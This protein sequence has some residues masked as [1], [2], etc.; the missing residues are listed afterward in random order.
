MVL[1]EYRTCITF[2]KFAMVVGSDCSWMH[3]QLHEDKALKWSASVLCRKP[4]VELFSSHLSVVWQT[5]QDFYTWLNVKVC[6]VL[7]VNDELAVRKTE[8]SD[9]IWVYAKKPES[10]LFCG[11]LRAIKIQAEY[12]ILGSHCWA[13]FCPLEPSSCPMYIYTY[14]I[15]TLS[16]STEN[17]YQM[18]GPWQLCISLSR[19]LLSRYLKPNFFIVFFCSIFFWHTQL[20]KRPFSYPSA[21]NSASVQ[22]ISLT[23]STILPF[24]FRPRPSLFL[25]I[26]IQ[27]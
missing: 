25:N 4:A 23:P 11:R 24:H 7:D 27:A 3:T 9:C 8:V 20:W 19:T 5:G 2:E 15:L 22:C 13:A 16:I 1:A 18:P 12:R 10:V 14:D 26:V 21:S 6:F 17:C